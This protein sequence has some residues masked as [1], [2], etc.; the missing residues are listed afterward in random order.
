MAEEAITVLKS[1]ANTTMVWE[2]V[3][4]LLQ[5]VFLYKIFGASFFPVYDIIALFDMTVVWLHGSNI[6]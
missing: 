3:S 4:G 6:S 2:D 1:I 5:Y